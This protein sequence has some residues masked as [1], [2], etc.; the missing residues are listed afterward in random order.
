MNRFHKTVLSSIATLL[1]AGVLAAGAHAQIL[2]GGFE[3]GINPPGPGGSQ[4][5]G[6]GSTAIVDWTVLTTTQVSW[7]GNGAFGVPGASNGGNDYLDIT[8]N[9]DTTNGTYTVGTQTYYTSGGVYQTFATTAGDTYDVSY[10]L[11]TDSYYNANST[12][13]IEAFISDTA[14]TSYSSLDLGDPTSES[15]LASGHPAG[16]GEWTEESFDFVATG[17]STTLTLIGY[18]AVGIGGNQY[19][20]LDNV[21]VEDLGN[22]SQ[23]GNGVPDEAS[24]LALL[25][26]CAAAALLVSRRPDLARRR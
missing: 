20:G 15:G 16:R 1:V 26:A 10:L 19:I 25:A 11:G 14:P 12:P 3:Q 22:L 7:D 23:G 18:S 2:N 6:N 4:T 13:G 21:S 9:N 5:Y 17:S 24:T 8:G